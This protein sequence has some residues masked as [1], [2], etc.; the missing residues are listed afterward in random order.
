MDKKPQ[1]IPGTIQTMKHYITYAIII[2]IAAHLSIAART[3]IA[4]K[5]TLLDLADR[6][7]AIDSD[8][9]RDLLAEVRNLVSSQSSEKSGAYVAGIMDAMNRPDHYN[10]IWHEGYN[11]GQDVRGQMTKSG[12]VA[13]K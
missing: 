4:R 6:K 12:E 9:I 8:Q 10:E 7:A 5:D 11:R 3:E 13:A 1:G 2:S